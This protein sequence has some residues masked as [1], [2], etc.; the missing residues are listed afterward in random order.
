MLAGVI[1]LVRFQSLLGLAAKRVVDELIARIETGAIDFPQPVRVLLGQPAHRLDAVLVACRHEL[2]KS[3]G[4]RFRRHSHYP[5]AA[6][7]LCL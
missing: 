1:S 4:I 3:L 6:R 7:R 5:G 2:G